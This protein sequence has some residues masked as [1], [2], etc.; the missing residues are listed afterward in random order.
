VKIGGKE[1]LIGEGYQ[2][3][4]APIHIYPRYGYTSKSRRY[5]SPVL[6][7]ESPSSPAG[8]E[9]ILNRLQN[10]IKAGNPVKWSTRLAA[11]FANRRRAAAAAAAAAAG[12]APAAAPSSGG[13]QLPDLRFPS[14]PKSI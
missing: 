11:Q 13:F 2:Q 14:P 7:Q 4:P 3:V 10:E 1:F 12:N 5:E 9:Q 8:P 6:A